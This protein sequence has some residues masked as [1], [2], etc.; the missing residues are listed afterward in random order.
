M[1][2]LLKANGQCCSTRLAKMSV[3]LNFVEVTQLALFEQLC[4]LLN[5]SRHNTKTGGRIP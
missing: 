2:T 4:S 1:K 3:D 5:T